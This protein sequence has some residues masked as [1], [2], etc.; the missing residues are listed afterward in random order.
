[1]KKLLLIVPVL[2]ILGIIFYACQDTLTDNELNN[3]LSKPAKTKVDVPIITCYSSTQV[4]I[5]IQV[6]APSGSGATGL[7]AGFSIQWMTKAAYEANGNM[8]YSSDDPR[9]CKASFSGNANLSRYNLAAGECVTIKVGEFLLDEGASVHCGGDDPECTRCEENLE[10]GTKYVFRV[11]AHATNTL[12]RSD[13]TSNLICSTL[14]CGSEEQCTYT[15]G[16]WKTH[17]PEGCATG[18]NSNEW[19]ATELTLGNVVYTDS[20]LCT[21]LNT[22]AGGNGLIA[23]AHQLIAAKLNM[24]NGAD[25]PTKVEEAIY[26]ADVLIGD[27]VIPPVGTGSL[28]PNVTG[29]L[30]EEL[31]NYNEGATGPGHCGN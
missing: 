28:K 26:A 9:L 17:G 21:I 19:P 4:S 15:Q 22:P 13:F 31:A 16:F 11:F 29:D 2:L 25:V 14:D 23:L 7:P 10:C 3:N 8:W 5:T 18:N 20:K 6:C 24:L 30:T 27:L 1:M 12:Q